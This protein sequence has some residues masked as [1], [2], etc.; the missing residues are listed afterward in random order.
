MEVLE[1]LDSEVK[2]LHFLSEVLEEV[3]CKEEI[4]L[5]NFL[6]STKDPEEDEHINIIINSS[7]KE[8]SK[9]DNRIKRNI[10]EPK[11]CMNKKSN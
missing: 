8:G 6:L 3:S 5:K 7:K 2:R 4:Y 1:D 10:K 9:D 11:I